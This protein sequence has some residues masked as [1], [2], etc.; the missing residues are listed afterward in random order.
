MTA[1]VANKITLPS[2]TGNSGKN[3]RTVTKTVGA[4]S[5]HTQFWVPDMAVTA[6]G[7]YFFTSSQQSIVQTPHDGTATG[8]FWLQMPAAATATAILRRLKAD[9]SAN[10][11]TVS[12]TAPTV[13][14]TKFTFTGTAS[15]A[16]AS[17]LPYQ[18]AGA[19]N[20]LVIRTAVTGMTVTVG[21]RLGVM[22]L[23]AI[24]TAVGIYGG[25][26]EILPFS[27]FGWQRGHNLEIAPG[28]GLLIY[29]DV[30]GTASDPRKASF[31]VEWMELDLS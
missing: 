2:D 29:Q 5:V 30:G 7:K 23:P 20:Q 11:A 15:G 22:T 17:A 9:Y 13:S 24:L 19:A 18:T 14:F 8:F 27:P 26:E 3:I 28:E 16:T 4:D 31:Q 25:S 21:Q 6:L 12:I 1:P 10:A